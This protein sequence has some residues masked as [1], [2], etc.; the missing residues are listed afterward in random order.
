[1]YLAPGV[2][3]LEATRRMGR[4][5]GVPDHLIERMRA[6]LARQVGLDWEALE[7]EALLPGLGHVPL[8]VLYSEDD[9]EVPRRAVDRILRHWP[10]AELRLFEGLG[11]RGILWDPVAVETAVDFLARR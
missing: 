2:S 4:M 8:R 10:D 7:P 1:M 6:N 11:H 9:V 5:L 3:P